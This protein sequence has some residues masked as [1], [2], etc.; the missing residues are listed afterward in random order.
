MQCKPGHAE[1]KING[2]GKASKIFQTYAMY[3]KAHDLCDLPTHMA[4]VQDQCWRQGYSL[5]N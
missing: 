5:F 3:L 2:G 4:E 1:L